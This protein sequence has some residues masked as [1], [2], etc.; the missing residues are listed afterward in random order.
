IGAFTDNMSTL[1]TL[2]HL[3]IP[4]WFVC[5]AKNNPDA[6]IDC[7]ADLIAEDSSRI[8]QLPSGFRVD[9]TDAEPSHNI[10][11]EGPTNKPECFAAMNAYL[12]SLLFPSTVFGSNQIQSLTS[13][14]KAILTRAP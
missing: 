3:G 14:Q 11:W 6:R 7:S 4:V 12:Q 9:G 13:L 8:I 1:D 10:V 2:Y 5:P